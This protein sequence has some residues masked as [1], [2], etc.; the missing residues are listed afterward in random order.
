MSHDRKWVGV[1]DL[2]AKSPEEIVQVPAW[3]YRNT[4][5]LLENGLRTG[6]EVDEPEGERILSMSDTLAKKLASALRGE[7]ERHG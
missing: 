2:D 4:L 3:A 6:A 1:N 5:D 7:V